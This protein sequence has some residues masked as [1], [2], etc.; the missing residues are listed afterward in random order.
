MV[1]IDAALLALER[2]GQFRLGFWGVMLV[3]LA[4]Y[5]SLHA[6]WEMYEFSMDRFTGTE[7]QPDGMEKATRNNLSG[8]AGALV[9]VV[10]LS[11]WQRAG[12]LGTAVVDPLISFI[13]YKV[14]P[15]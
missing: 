4:A 7:L 13:P 5:T 10:L 9:G 15:R 11:M 8:I 2:Q 6:L 3:G 12:N 14:V 1:L